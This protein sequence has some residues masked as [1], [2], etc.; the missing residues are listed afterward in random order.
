[1]DNTSP[2]TVTHVEST[3]LL[4]AANEVEIPSVSGDTSPALV[5][6]DEPTTSSVSSLYDFIFIRTISL[7][8]KLDTRNSRKRPELSRSDQSRSSQPGNQQRIDY[9]RMLTL[10]CQKGHSDEF[11]IQLREK[12][13]EAM[14][15][16]ERER[17][18][19]SLRWRNGEQL[20]P[21][22]SRDGHEQALPR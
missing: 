19:P 9:A 17:N 14:K 6:D 3:T 2:A 11:V 1:M 4:S 21:L 15:K 16:L 18:C 12:E 5:I 22:G 8:M 7:C 10:Q 13:I 20:P